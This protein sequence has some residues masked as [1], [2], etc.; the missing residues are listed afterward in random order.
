MFGAMLASP[1]VDM[2]EL[3]DSNTVIGI[4]ITIM[5]CSASTSSS[6][7]TEKI[8]KASAELSIF[9][10]NIVL[11]LYGIIV[12]VIYLLYKNP[13]LLTAGGFLAG[14]NFYTYVALLS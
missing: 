2:S 4:L 14:W 6:I 7:Y 11:Y 9:Y 1:E 13:G 3:K 5:M 8:F 12:N 10:K